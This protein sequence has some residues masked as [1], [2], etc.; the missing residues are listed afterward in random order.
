MARTVIAAIVATIAVSDAALAQDGAF[1][2]CIASLRDATLAKGVSAATFDNVAA[3]LTPNDAATFL[4]AQP[5]FVTP[6]WDYLAALVDD[7]RVSDGKAAMRRWSAGLHAA[8][9][10]FGVDAAT[11]TALWG[12]E[13][14]FGTEFGKRP[15]LQSLATLSCIGRRQDYFREQFIDALRILDHGDVKA[16]HFYG[17]WAGA[18]GHTQFMPSTFLRFAVDME[19]NGHPDVVDSIPDA[20]G[21]TANYLRHAGWVSGLPWGFEV[22]VPAGYDG[23]SGRRRKAPM[24][25]WAAR[26]ITRAAGGSL[27]QGL[28]SLFEPA[29]PQ[30]PAFLVTHNF[31][32]L[33]AY[34]QAES[35]ALAISLLSDR[36]RGKPGL[37]APWPTNDPGLSRAERREMQALLIRHG[38][39]VGEP[40][41]AMGEKTHAAIT[42]YQTRR[43]M[44]ADGRAAKS[45]LDALRA[46]R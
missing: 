10:R 37:V 39:D 20:L 14:N 6:I 22:R 12:V 13:S 1:R 34:N 40:N 33:L 23:P 46:G 5:E 30:G 9:T 27:G 42:D 41:G 4:D 3:K 2:R 35:Y 21:S 11:I 38:Y 8:E 18:F 44:T 24:A 29:G 7:E 31:D 16:D 28:A 17:S 45:V 32:V 26:G 19:G 25:V 15:V 36:L 43:G